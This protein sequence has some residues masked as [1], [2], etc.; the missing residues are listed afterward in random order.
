MKFING[1]LIEYAK[2][3]LFDVIIHG[4]NCFNTMGAG[5][6]LKIKKEF[7]SAYLADTKTLSGTK[8]KL[9]SYTSVFIDKYQFT[10]INGYTQYRY[11]RGK[12]FD[13][14]AFSELLYKIKN[15]FPDKRIGMNMIGCGLAGGDSEKVLSIITNIMYNTNITIVLYKK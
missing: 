14:N 11:G 2:D 4:C 10:I 9:G 13:Y 6:A 15:D 8:T 1:D 7:P 5:I 12:H 3:G